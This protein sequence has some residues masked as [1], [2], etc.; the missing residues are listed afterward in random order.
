[1]TTNSVPWGCDLELVSYEL[2]ESIWNPTFNSVSLSE[3]G[4]RNLMNCKLRLN[5]VILTLVLVYL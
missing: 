5:Y 3:F 2:H 4:M 1:M